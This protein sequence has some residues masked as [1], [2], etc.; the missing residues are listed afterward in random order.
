MFHNTIFYFEYCAEEVLTQIS[1]DIVIRGEGEATF[2][3]I[4]KGLITNTL[5]LQSI[6]GIT[7]RKGAL[8]YKFLVI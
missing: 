3:E 6:H 5:E 4:V 2:Y 8:V 1:A 7:Y